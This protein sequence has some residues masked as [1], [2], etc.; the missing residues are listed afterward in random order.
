M[1]EKFKNHLKKHTRVYSLGFLALVA[2]CV[3]YLYVQVDELENNQLTGRINVV[4]PKKIAIPN[5]SLTA[6][7]DVSFGEEIDKDSLAITA[8]KIKLSSLGT[9]VLINGSN[10]LSKFEIS[11]MNYDYDINT[12]TFTIDDAIETINGVSAL[13]EFKI[14]KGSVYLNPAILQNGKKLTLTFSPPE[15]VK[16]GSTNLYTLEAT[17]RGVR[18]TNSVIITIESDGINN[19]KKITGDY[20]LTNRLEN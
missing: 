14:K 7:K 20:P 1:F 4:S 10:E 15:R 6:K 12:I 5:Y 3:S 17:A 18:T 9:S 11:S 2:V 13:S 16:K 19:G 8:P